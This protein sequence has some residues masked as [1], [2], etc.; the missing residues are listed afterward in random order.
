MPDISDDLIP[1]TP[2]KPDWERAMLEKVAM[3]SIREQ[4][5]NRRW[6]TFV[7]MAWLLFFAVLAPTALYRGPLNMFGMGAGIAALIVSLNLLPP[8][9]V[10]GIFLGVQYIQ[11]ASDPTNSHNTWI[12]GFAKVDTAAIL[13]KSLPYTWV[14]C[15]LMLLY[16]VMTRW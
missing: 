7:R 9:V 15:I 4:Q 14:M 8:M 10:A 16:V 13:K 12:G 1:A 5:A 3:A 2:R 11:A 6:K